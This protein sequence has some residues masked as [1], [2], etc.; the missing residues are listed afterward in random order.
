[1][2]PA[3]V[4]DAL[5]L[6]QAI[7]VSKT[8]GAF[9]LVNQMES[10]WSKAI[11]LDASFDYAGPERS[12]GLLYRDTPS[13]GSIGSR[14]KARQHLERALELA[15][16]YP[17]NRLNLIE[18]ELQWGDRKAARVPARSDHADARLSGG[19]VAGAAEQI[20]GDG[21][22]APGALVPLQ[23]PRPLSYFVPKSRSPASPSPGTM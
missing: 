17:E 20:R 13:F 21:P 3:H 16:R 7:N 10:E 19:I 5:P 15:P 22:R 12:L 4:A 8:F 18:S 6:F 1:M 2:Q 9:K 11:A 23:P 14:T